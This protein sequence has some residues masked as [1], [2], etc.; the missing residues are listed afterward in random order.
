VGWSS[1]TSNLKELITSSSSK[2]DDDWKV[3]GRVR[4]ILKGGFKGVLISPFLPTK[5]RPNPETSRQMIIDESLD[6]CF[7]R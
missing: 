7:F 4:G 6:I 1:S 3:R 2:E 5:E